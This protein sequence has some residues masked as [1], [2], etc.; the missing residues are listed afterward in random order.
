V[1]LSS[2]GY[3]GYYPWIDKRHHLYGVFEGD[4]DNEIAAK[5]KFPAFFSSPQLARLVAGAIE[6]A[7][8]LHTD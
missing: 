8:T 7:S 1:L 2:P 6:A 3:Y 5:A 4:A